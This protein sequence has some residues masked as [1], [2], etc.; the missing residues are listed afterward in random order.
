MRSF[1]QLFA[2]RTDV[3][4]TYLV[5]EQRNDGK[6]KGRGTTHHKDLTE[7]HW[8]DHLEG[9]KMLG[10]V[11]IRLDGT[12]SW[13]AGDIDV[14]NIDHKD[15][16]RRCQALEIPV[17][18]CRSKSGGA[19]L[20]CFVNGAIPAE[21]AMRIMRHWLIQLGHPKSEVFPKQEHLS[22]ESIGNWINLPYFGGDKTD[23]WAY[24]LNAEQ[25]NLADF[26][27]Y[28]NACSPNEEE[29]NQ[30]DKTAG[31][32]KQQQSKKEKDPLEQAP[33]CVQTMF[34]DRVTEGGRNNALTHVGIYYLKSNPENWRDDLIAA[35]FRIF[36]DPLPQDEVNQIARNVS[37]SKYEYLCQLEPMCSLCD[38]E[39][40][41]TR[42]WGVGPQR[43]ID[44]GDGNIDR[45]IKI[46]SDPPVYCVVMNGIT[47]KMTTDQLLSPGKFRR[48]V[49]EITGELI[50]PLKE[51]AHEARIQSTKIEVE[52]APSEVNVDGQVIEA[53]E[54]WCEVHLPSS[55]HEREILR[56][57]PWYDRDNSV[58]VFRSTDVI[59]AF[60][61][62]K[63][64]NV[65]D[66]DVWVALRGNGAR[67]ENHKI[68][69]RQTKVWVYPVEV[70]WFDIPDS[71]SF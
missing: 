4:G 3:Y 49:Y 64:F 5:T 32:E 38:K 2:G 29:L 7:A 48:R 23:R 37:K 24:G 35:N 68:E 59:A 56:G 33:P 14:Y 27:Q 30:I 15:L 31:K 21:M 36:D 8:A 20:Y 58:I 13:F 41:M 17:V 9:R 47:V 34:A 70:P 69:G 26:I 19:H 54:Q 63:K 10:V 39:T 60:R 62:S 71:E 28:A 65:A 51:R 6:Q 22:E 52:E 50:A 1:A 43:G 57:N 25:L 40:C 11:P 67:R 53:F 61:R 42:K 45:I 44:Y 66:R 12:V 16:L 46:N 18:I 55:R